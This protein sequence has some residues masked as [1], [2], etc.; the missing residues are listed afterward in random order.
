[1]SER[2]P[3]FCSTY[4]GMKSVLTKLFKKF[5]LIFSLLS[6][7]FGARAP[8]LGPDHIIKLQEDSFAIGFRN[9]KEI[10]F[11][12]PDF[13]MTAK[14]PLD[15]IPTGL[16]TD[17]SYKK[18]FVTLNGPDK[19]VAIEL[20]SCQ[21]IAESTAPPGACSPVFDGV[22]KR[23]YICNR[24]KNS[25]SA[26]DA[27]TLEQI[28]E[29]KVEREPG[30]AI[31]DEERGILYASNQFTTEPANKEK[32]HTYI[33]LL[34]V[35]NNGK[36]IKNIKMD[37]GYNN[38]KG[39]ALS[40]DR[41]TIAVVHNLA[42]FFQGT[43]QVEWGWMNSSYVTF[44]STE[45]QALQYV[46]PLDDVIR[47]AASPWSVA[48]TPD[49]K[50]LLVA[51]AG[52][53]EISVID[54]GSIM[55]RMRFQGNKVSYMDQHDLMGQYR[56]RVSTGGKGPRHFI[57]SGSR[58]IVANFFTDTLGIIDLDLLP[59]TSD[60]PSPTKIETQIVEL[61]SDYSLSLE[62]KGEM[63][64]GD[65]MLC[66]QNWQSCIGCHPDARADGF[67]WD[68][69][70]DG[71]DNLKNTKSL[72]YSHQTPP[73]MVTG[74]RPNAEYAVRSGIR[75]ILFS[76]VDEDQAKAMDAYLKS[77]TP[78]PSPY[79]V[80]GELSPKALEGKEIFYDS[81]VGCFRCHYGNHYTDQKLHNVGT[82]VPGDTPHTEWD[83]PTLI[84]VWRTA[85]YLHDGSAA[86]IMD[87][88]TTGNQKQ[89]HGRTKHLSKEELEALA[90][91]VLSL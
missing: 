91:Y 8:W 33:Y 50:K 64:F 1:M 15:A 86:T 63:Y 14:I 35:W 54:L 22:Q 85:P 40:P 42:K 49:S 47:G 53:H 73:A 3:F 77:L 30:S 46:I 83:T 66:K 87:V 13:K 11:Y 41:K 23:I 61:N 57:Q 84:E 68:L 43:F 10:R 62:G 55:E 2:W 6:I 36:A 28:W 16:A 44:I 4:G 31:L 89:K 79:L 76:Q 32:V 48:W 71:I 27:N 37:S 67:N 24:W 26:F 51:H 81:K 9:S 70:N 18:I 56:H 34:D 60:F 75:G 82:A 5:F 88:L 25:I 19:I 78:E 39:M 45:E 20:E 17:S 65:A 69:M 12:S 7:G 72:L 29:V 21:I 90:E 74:I 38:Y 52:V 59:E 80:N 58:V